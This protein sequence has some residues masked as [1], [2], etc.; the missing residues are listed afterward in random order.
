MDQYLEKHSDPRKTPAL[1]N[2]IAGAYQ[3][4]QDT[5][6]AAYYYR[7]IA[8]KYPD[9][10]GVAR[11]RY[12]LA[13]CYDDNKMRDKALEQYT[14]LKDSFSATSYGQMGQKKFDQHRF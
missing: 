6:T 7:W 14:I 3:A 5:R 13:E 2:V 4:F 1:L 8:E 10:E 9:Y 12:E 11:V